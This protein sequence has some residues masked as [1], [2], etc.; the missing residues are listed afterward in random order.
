MKNRIKKYTKKFWEKEKI[1][2][3]SPSEEEIAE[4]LQTWSQFPEIC[5]EVR[6]LK[7]AYHK[8]LEG[9]SEE[10]VRKVHK[11]YGKSIETLNNICAEIMKLM[12]EDVEQV[13]KGD[14]DDS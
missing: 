6:N 2:I 14:N 11:K 12:N 5:A 8:I 9:F 13:S 7:E 4:S 3:P 10:E 1:A